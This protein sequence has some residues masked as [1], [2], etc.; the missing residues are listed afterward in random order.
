M[1]RDMFSWLAGET[2][3]KKQQNET[4][5]AR[6]LNPTT[7]QPLTSPSSAPHTPPVLLR[8]TRDDGVNEEESE[9]KSH[10]LDSPVSP[11]FQPSPLGMKWPWLLFLMPPGESFYWACPTGRD[12]VDT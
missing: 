5:A 1:P 11:L 7:D 3:L 12:G 2:S 9:W 4:R 6:P 8:Q 10:T